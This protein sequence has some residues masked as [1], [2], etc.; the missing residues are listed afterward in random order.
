MSVAAITRKSAATAMSRLFI[1]R[2]YLTYSSVIF[3]IGMSKMFACSCRIKNS[4][5]SSGPANSPSLSF[6]SSLGPALISAVSL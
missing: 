6:N 3:A 5:R 4:N 1:K 2:M